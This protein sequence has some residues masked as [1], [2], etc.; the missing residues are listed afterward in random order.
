MNEVSKIKGR[1]TFGFIEAFD[2]VSHF[3]DHNQVGM[4]NPAFWVAFQGVNHGF[5]TVRL[6]GIVG[7]GDVNILSPGEFNAVVPVLI[8]SAAR[9]LAN[10]NPGILQG[11]KKLPRPIFRMII[12]NDQFPVLPCLIN[13]RLNPLSKVGAVVQIRETDG[14]QWG[15]SRYS[16]DHLIL[17]MW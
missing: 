6:H 12:H 3:V 1:P 14:D 7:S 16:V 11:L 15:Q 8:H 4:G 10:V 17:A 5:D 2:L 9:G 13:D